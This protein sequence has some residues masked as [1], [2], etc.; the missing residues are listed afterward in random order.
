[1]KDD[2][3]SSPLNKA[4]PANPDTGADDRASGQNRPVLPPRDENWY[5]SLVEAVEDAIIVLDREWRIAY[6]ND[7]AA[8]SFCKSAGQLVSQRLQELFP[9]LEGSPL[10]AAI[11]QVVTTGTPASVTHEFPLDEPSGL[12]FENHLFPVPQGVLAIGIDITERKRIEDA[13]RHGEER[14]RRLFEQSLDAIYIVTRD[15]R[16][17]ECNQAWLDLLGYSREELDTLDAID[18]NAEPA[19]RADFLTRIAESGRLEDEVRLK[20]KD[21]SVIICD[22]RVVAL[23]DDSGQVIAFQGVHRDIT[24]RNEAQKALR[25]SERRFR[26]LYDNSMD[27]IVIATTDGVILEANQACLDMFHYSRDDL[28]SLNAVDLYADPAGREELLRRVAENS[29]VIS[30]VKYRSKE[31]SVF[32]GRVKVT[33]LYDDAGRVEVYQGIIYDITELTQAEERERDQRLFAGALMETSPACILVFDV[34]G[35]IVFANVE[36]DRVLGI[37]HEQ[38][39]GM[40]CGEEFRLFA[41]NGSRLDEEELPGCRVFRTEAPMYAVEYAFDS[42]TGRRILSISAAPLYDDTGTVSKVVTTIEDVTAVR[43]RALSLLESEA[44]YRSLFERSLD[45]VVLTDLQGRVVDAN[46]ATIAALGYSHEELVGRPFTAHMSAKNRQVVVDLLATVLG[47]G[48][49]PRLVE[50]TARRKDGA[51]LQVEINASLVSREAQTA[52]I[53]IVARDVSERKRREQEREESLVRLRD[54]MNATVSAMSAAVEMRDPYTAGH[55]AR[56]TTVAQAIAGEMGLTDSSLQALEVAGR[57][58]DLGKLRIPSEILT[59]P[60]KLSDVEYQLI[61][62]HPQA[63]Y[64]LLKGIDFP[65]PV[66]EIAYQHHE[67][68]DGSGY[69]RGLKGD[70]MLPEAR[71]LAVADVFEAMSSHRPYRPSLGNAAAMKEIQAHSGT[72]YDPLV[73]D[74]LT[75]LVDEKGFKLQ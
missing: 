28:K 19:D 35:R 53:E 61:R 37:P 25:E 30:E 8:R 70:E 4:C 38:L 10:M 6:A 26:E 40:I 21:G 20:R 18:I 67:R 73:V 63:S 68:I 12:W 16:I 74:A 60:G 50:F 51:E 69:P 36:A 54:A 65:W 45:M 71:V 34:A 15:G 5:R 66:A 43:Q 7:A 62:E 22:R 56:V 75:R 47:T 1:M 72:L 59:K 3:S 17:S 48:S 46:P 42:P 31:G 58:H 33:T 32:D 39:M 23:K 29:S 57:V 49:L 14:F 64:D 11:E 9:T 55:Q 2:Q 41:S 44:R 13:L 52:G 27:A 24:A